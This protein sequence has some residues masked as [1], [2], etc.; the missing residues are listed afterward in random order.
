MTLSQ[1]IGAAGGLVL[2]A[3]AASIFYFITKGFSKD[4]AFAALEQN[5]NEYQRPLEDLLKNISQHQLLARRSLAGQRDLKSRL[6]PAEERVDAAMQA[7]QAV[8]AKL[9]AA[10]QFT[11]EGLAMRKREHCRWDILRQE[12][13][14]LKRGLA[15]QSVESSDK[16][17]ARLI[18]NIRTMITHA[19]DTSNLILDPDLDSYYLMDATLIALPQTQDR[20][21]AIER[22]GE[23]VL[24]KGKIGEAD[25]I[26]LAVAAALLREADVDRVMAD[27]QTSLNEDRNFSGVSPS[28]QQRLPPASE[29]Y[30]EANQALLALL[31]KMIDAPDAPATQQEF[32]AAASAAREASFRLWRASVQELDGLL[33]RRIDGLTRARLWALIWTALALLAS[34]GVAAWVIH[35]ATRS[36]RAASGQLR[37][38]SEAIAA[39]SGK[40]ANTS[41]ELARRASEL[42][43][44]LEETAA[45]GEEINSMARQ[46]SESSRAAADLVTQSQERFVEA[47]QALDQMVTA[48]AEINEASDKISQIIKAIDAIAFQTNILALNAAVE[49]ARA[50]EA[51]M[52]FAVVADEVRNLAQRSAQAAK[53]TAALIE[54]SIAKAS[55]GEQKI[56]QL[57]AVIRAIVQDSAKIKTLVDGVHQSSQE[58]THGVE[59]VA[60]AITQMEQVTRRNAEAAEQSASTVGQLN[61]QSEALKQIVSRI[62]DIVGGS[63]PA[64]FQSARETRA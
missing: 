22:M 15:E 4:I 5:G 37:I 24:A 45:S 8:D 42:A 49:A 3:V 9:G 38:D 32:T 23:D 47:N 31:Q 1:Q 43:A 29:E 48:I 54:S 40:I 41:E 36:L 39:E 17:H 46:N 16:A 56:G 11:P 27:F 28:L 34:G 51:G 14:G 55:Q 25:R 64:A 61:S 63:G 26:R 53:D 7:L 33:Q 35:S 19:G 21:A 13:E 2:A 57:A 44:S 60:K 59:Q 20:L 50:G 18:A 58:Q 10:L 62:T 52:G 30:S 12:W 6:A